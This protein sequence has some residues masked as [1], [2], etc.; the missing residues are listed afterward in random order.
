[1]LD[2]IAGLPPPLTKGADLAPPMSAMKKAA[3]P[4]LKTVEGYMAAEMTEMAD[5]RALM[6]DGGVLQPADLAESLEMSLAA[7]A[8]VR[9][10]K[11]K[12]ALAM[13]SRVSF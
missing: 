8:R 6:Q 1:M 10:H 12:V 13:S 3:E 4:A 5:A 7:P 2:G 9:L 11:T